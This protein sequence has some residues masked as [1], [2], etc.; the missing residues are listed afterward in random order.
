M[1]NTI[2][3]FIKQLQLSTSKLGKHLFG[4]SEDGKI[5]R[6][7]QQPRNQFDSKMMQKNVK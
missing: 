6:D 5:F 3:I 7:G 1:L 2:S 4:E